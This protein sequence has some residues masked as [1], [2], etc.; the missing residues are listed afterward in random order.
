MAKTY[1]FLR[2]VTTSARD[3]AM[4]NAAMEK[5]EFVGMASSGGGV[6]ILIRQEAEAPV[7]V[8]P[9]SPP[10]RIEAEDIGKGGKSA[11]GS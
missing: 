4:L 3:E 2:F 11:G 1:K 6:V 7:P 10:V 5:A 9:A 8:K